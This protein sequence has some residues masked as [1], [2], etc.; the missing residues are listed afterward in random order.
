MRKSDKNNHENT[1]LESLRDLLFL[2][3]R[4]LENVRDGEINNK[5]AALIFTGSRTVTGVLKLGVEASKLGL[6]MIGGVDVNSGVKLVGSG[7]GD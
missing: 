1:K 2:N 3:L 7:P 5:K 6:S 4:T